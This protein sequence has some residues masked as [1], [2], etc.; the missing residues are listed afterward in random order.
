MTEKEVSIELPK[1]ENGYLPRQCPNCS[2]K[3]AVDGD[4]YQQEHYLNLRCP[5]CEWIEELDEFLTNEQVEYTE[6]V[7][8][9][10]VRRMMADEFEE[11]LEDVFSGSSSDFIELET[12]AGDIDFGERKTLSPHVSISTHQTTCSQCGFD[13]LVAENEDDHSCPVCR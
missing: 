6:A 5:Y 13:Y 2:R 9:N 3:F 7:A 12:D 4:T 1:D 10:E 8:E 11:A